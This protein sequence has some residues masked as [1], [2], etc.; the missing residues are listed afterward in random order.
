MESVEKN[1]SSTSEDDSGAESTQA[2]LL[3]SPW[4]ATSWL[5]LFAI[6]HFVGVFLYI[7]G[8]GGYLGA[9]FGANGEVVDPASIQKS[10][11][12]HIKTPAALTGMYLAQFCL[13]LP[14]LLFASKFDTQTRRATLALRAFELSS[15]WRWLPVLVVFLVAQML[16]V[17]ALGIEQGEFMQS[18]AGSR[19]L[20]LALVLVLAA[21]LLEEL[22]FRGYLFRAWRQSRL[23][24]SGTLLLTSTLFTLLHWG[25]YHWLQ[26]GFVFVLALVLGMARE[27]SGSV[28]LPMLLH[29]LNNLGAA[30]LVI[31]L[32]IL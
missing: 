17:K 3:P 28:L 24:F 13:I 8:Y 23:G 4:Y 21:P 25:Q 32:G 27:R 22:V 30:I 18:I 19:N 20:P 29:A 26:L 10:V 6:L 5:T 11:E 15:L 1:I 14:V 31:Y 12:A 7:A 9:Q 16:T 2:G